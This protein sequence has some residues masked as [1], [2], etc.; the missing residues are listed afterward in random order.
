MKHFSNLLLAFASLAAGSALALEPCRPKD[1][2]V[3]AV[4]KI[5][6]GAVGRPYDLALTVFPSFEAEYGVRMI[7]VDVYLVTL[8]PSVWEST[9]MADGK[10]G[11]HHDIR[12]AHADTSVRKASIS[13]KLAAEVRQKY[14]N[15]ISALNPSD[16][17]GL[18]GT[19]YR[20]VVRDAGC[21]ETWSPQPNSANRRLVELAEL[22]VAYARQ[23]GQSFMSRSE[24]KIFRALEPNK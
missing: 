18:D 10:G 17:G 4:N 16:A 3:E 5:I 7:G 9:V 12:K 1:D 11:Y 8:R 24:K 20:F 15:A 2:Y 21:G 22:L 6:D 23:S 19:T 13:P 14:V